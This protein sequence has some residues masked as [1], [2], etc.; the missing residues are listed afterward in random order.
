MD[1]GEYVCVDMSGYVWIWVDMCGYVWIWVDMSVGWVGGMLVCGCV[2][3]Y[4]LCVCLYVRVYVCVCVC[5]CVC[6]CVCVFVCMCVCGYGCGVSRSYAYVCIYAYIICAYLLLMSVW[7]DGRTIAC[8]N[9]YLILQHGDYITV[10][11]FYKLFIYLFVILSTQRYLEWRQVKV[12]KIYFLWM[13][14]FLE[15]EKTNAIRNV[16]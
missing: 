5:V 1:M 13:G 14:R 15:R 12:F 16:F 8:L 11:H 9:S 7:T 10:C 3:M 2:F 6:M 4:V